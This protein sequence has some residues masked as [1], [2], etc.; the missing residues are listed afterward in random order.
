[1]VPSGENHQNP[2]SEAVEIVGAWD[3]LPET[4][5]AGIIAMVRAARRLDES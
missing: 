2:P 4:V 5:R 3:S 1:M